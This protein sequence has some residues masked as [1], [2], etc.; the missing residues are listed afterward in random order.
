[1]PRFTFIRNIVAVFAMVVAALCGGGK[2]VAEDTGELVIVELRGDPALRSE[3]A[4]RPGDFLRKL[5]KDRYPHWFVR[6]KGGKI[7]IWS[8]DGLGDALSELPSP[9]GV[10]FYEV[11][12]TELSVLPIAM[13]DPSSTSN[14]R[15]KLRTYLADGLKSLSVKLSRLF[16]MARLFPHRLS[17]IQFSVAPVKSPV[18]LRYWRP[19]GLPS[20]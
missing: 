20:A 14:L 13:V 16:L 3:A 4:K 5:L 19:R 8:P 17:V 9:K 15:R 12:K 11:A 2:A 7:T 18:I 6:T 10:G 1:M